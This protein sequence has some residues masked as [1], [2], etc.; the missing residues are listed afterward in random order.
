MNVRYQ[1]AVLAVAFALIGGATGCTQRGEKVP[2]DLFYKIET[3]GVQSGYAVVDTQLVVEDGEELIRLEQRNHFESRIMGADMDTESRMT[4]LLEPAG[5]RVRSHEGESSSST[6]TARWTIEITDGQARGSSSLKQDD[7]VLDLPP[8]AIVENTIFFDHIIADFAGTDLAEKTYPV[9]DIIDFEIRDTRYEKH[10]EET[11]TLA[12]TKHDAVVVDRS[13]E[14][15]GTRARMWIDTSTAM[16]VKIRQQDGNVISLADPSVVNKVKRVNMDQ[17]IFDKTDVAIADVSGITY[18]KVRATI[19]PIGVQPTPETLNVPGQKFTG[20]VKDNLIE[21]VFEIEHKRFD[22]A[23]APAFPI[24][25]TAPEMAEYLAADGVYE[26]DDEV[27]AEKARDITAGA[28]DAWGAATR[29]AQWVSDEIGYA[30]PGGGTARNTYDIRAGECGAHS[31]LLAT[32]CRTVGIPARMVWGCMYTPN[33]GGSFGQHGW[34]EVYMGAAG[35]IPLDATVGEA[36]FVDSGHIRVANFGSLNTQLNAQQFE[37]LDYRVVGGGVESADAA[38]ERYAPYVGEYRQKESSTDCEVK[39]MD[40]VL[41]VD[42]PNQAMLALDDPDEQGRWVCKMAR[43]A[44]VSFDQPNQGETG[45]IEAFTLHEVYSLPRQMDSDTAD[46]HVPAEFLPYLGRYH[47]A[48]LAADFTVSWK[49]AGLALQHPRRNRAFTLE[50]IRAGRAWKTRGGPYTIS[51][52]TDQNGNVASMTLD[53]VNEF[54]K[55]NR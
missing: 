14:A 5:K 26:S 25:E 52:V 22:G 32:F 28:T 40:G 11:L 20:T 3:G 33:N 10:A 19:R 17:Y 9:L 44:Y 23:G 8:G 7:M 45:N 6:Q 30:I 55:K 42:I 47:M 39:V 38:R 48:A 27:L 31:V 4:F 54:R 46:A 51:F 50:R 29:L 41:V 12:G 36:D 21:G 49:R 2:G 16:V 37:I 35:W 18:M 53:A 15:T 24:P 1:N 34:T 13:V 43:N